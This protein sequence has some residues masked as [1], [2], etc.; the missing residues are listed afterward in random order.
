[1]SLSDTVKRKTECKI[2]SWHWA[3]SKELLTFSASGIICLTF[4]HLATTQVKHSIE[5][6]DQG[7]G[8]K[9]SLVY[10]MH[11]KTAEMM[12]E[13]SLWLCF[14]SNLDAGKPNTWH[15]RQLLG[16]CC[17]YSSGEERSQL[18]WL[19]QQQHRAVGSVSACRG[20]SSVGCAEVQF[21]PWVISV[22]KR[23]LIGLSYHIRRFASLRQLT[24]PYL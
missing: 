10:F 5:S 3:H 24:D 7:P 16:T 9:T 12:V 15:C 23:V 14:L 22:M 11:Y 1:M 17:C 21:W 18:R 8:E 19:T 6:L 4:W 13:E 20:S 2:I